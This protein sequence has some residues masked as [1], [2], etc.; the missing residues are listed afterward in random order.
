MMK[1]KLIIVF[2]LIIFGLANSRSI[3]IQCHGD[4][5][6]SF[7]SYVHN[8]PYII[9]VL[10]KN[11]YQKD[12][13]IMPGFAGF[14]KSNTENFYVQSISKKGLIDTELSYLYPTIF[15]NILKLINEKRKMNNINN[16]NNPGSN[17]QNNM[18]TATNLR[19]PFNPKSNSQQL[20][21]VPPKGISD[22]N[23]IPN[24]SEQTKGPANSIKEVAN[25]KEIESKQVMFIDEQKDQLE[26]PDEPITNEEKQYAYRHFSGFFF[27]YTYSSSCIGCVEKILKLS[28]LFPNIT[29]KFYYTNIYDNKTIDRS[30]FDNKYDFQITKSFYFKDECIP[31]TYSYLQERRKYGTLA[32]DEEKDKNYFNNFFKC[33]QSKYKDIIHGVTTY[34]NI[35]FIKVPLR[36]DFSEIYNYIKN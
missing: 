14:T 10:S 35:E 7:I 21:I 31:K 26:I 19:P 28:K 27:I 33:V 32:Y 1:M 20:L 34:R 4:C 23:T 15:K 3:L 8:Q 36:K 5:S 13:M 25:S 11:S 29:F 9:Q 30:Y 22:S 18:S 6:K 17:G 24:V 12:Y 2:A 16:N